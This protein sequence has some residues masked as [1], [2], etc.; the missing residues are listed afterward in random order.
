[1]NE[2]LDAVPL[3][4][5]KAVDVSPIDSGGRIATLLGPQEPP[6]NSLIVVHGT[7]LHGRHLCDHPVNA[8]HLAHRGSCGTSISCTAL[9]LA[10][11]A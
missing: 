11:V 3:R 9:D 5:G 7:G 6:G 8:R 4:P 10:G 1:M 2:R